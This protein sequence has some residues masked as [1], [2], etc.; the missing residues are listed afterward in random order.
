MTAHTPALDYGQSNRHVSA[1]YQKCIDVL[2][3]TKE[4]HDDHIDTEVTVVLFFDLSWSWES[5]AR[6]PRASVVC[7]ATLERALIGELEL[8][9]DQCAL[10]FGQEQIEDWCAEV[11]ENGE[12]TE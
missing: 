11:S 9:K 2:K 4:Q 7:T 6:D 5:D 12:R 10:A 8:T 3:R 1:H